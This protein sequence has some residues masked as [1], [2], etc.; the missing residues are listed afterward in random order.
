MILLRSKITKKV[1]NLLFLNE[2]ES[3]YV[4]E[5]AKLLKEDPSNVYKKLLELKKEGV[6]SDE[7]RGKE[8]YFFLNRKY[9]FLKEYKKIILKGF[10]FE[11]ILKEKLSKLKNIDSVYIFGSYAKNR[12]SLESDIDVLIVG[13]FDT[14]KVQKVILEIQ[15]LTGREINSVELTKK[16]FEKRMRKKDPFLKDIFSKEYIKLL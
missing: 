14:L 13:D 3:F 15:K 4:N 2:K 5:L 10:G 7:F 11:K 8:R 1:L 16:E 6:L 9:P 12:L